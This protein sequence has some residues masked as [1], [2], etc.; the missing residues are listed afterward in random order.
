MSKALDFVKA[1]LTASSKLDE[2]EGR[3]LTASE[4]SNHIRGI[5]I[6]WMAVK[7]LLHSNVIPLGVI[8][9]TAAQKGSL[10]SAFGFFLS[11]IFM[12]SGGLASMIETENKYNPE[13]AYSFMYDEFKPLYMPVKVKTLEPA[14]A[15]ITSEIKKYRKLPKA[16]RFPYLMT[17]D[18]IAGAPPKAA[19]DAIEKDGYASKRYAEAALLWSSYFKKLSS[20]LLD[21]D[22]L[23][24]FTNHLKEKMQ[25]GRG[26]F[27]A[28][29]YTKQGGTAQD[30][31]A[32]HYF[33]IRRIGKV[34]LANREGRL[35]EFSTDKCGMG[36]DNRKIVIP[37]VWRF[38]TDPESG[39]TRQLSTFALDE[40]TARLFAGVDANVKPPSRVQAYFK[41]LGVMCEAKRYHCTAL[42]IPKKSPLNGNEMGALLNSNQEIQ[43]NFRQVCGYNNWEDV[44]TGPVIPVKS[45][46]FIV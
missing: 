34:D 26:A 44:S 28:K 36:P 7:Y 14:Q 8:T 42:G 27:Q 13:F 15:Y 35:L 45:T 4:A 30:F 37:A 29:Q 40:A 5:G 25:E 21:L 20:D 38:T 19:V 46:P 24:Y 3:I 33:Y 41:S 11:Q 17:I 18:S 6:P 9:G 2:G 31:H 22:V 10:K 12:M 43:E 39:V 16:D 1:S 32:M 23:I